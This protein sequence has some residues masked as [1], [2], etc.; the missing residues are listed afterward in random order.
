MAAGDLLL[1]DMP[2][3][4]VPRYVTVT[5]NLGSKLPLL[6]TKWGWAAPYDNVYGS[7]TDS[8][9]NAIVAIAQ[10][11]YYHRQPN[12]LGSYTF[13]WDLIAECEYGQTPSVAAQ[14]E[15]AKLCW[16]D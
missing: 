7:G 14:N 3:V 1:P 13:D 8:K 6:E 5:T 11:F 9:D 10:L 15:V 12:A 16:R 2:I 4:P